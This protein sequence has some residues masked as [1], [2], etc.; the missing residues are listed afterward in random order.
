[1][2][3]QIAGG[4]AVI[5]PAIPNCRKWWGALAI[6]VTFYGTRIAARF[7]SNC[8]LMFSFSL[9]SLKGCQ[10]FL[11]SL[12]ICMNLYIGTIKEHT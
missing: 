1:M 7:C 6:Q 4:I 3:F 5:P 10:A 12:F 9:V 11:T 8:R 2:D